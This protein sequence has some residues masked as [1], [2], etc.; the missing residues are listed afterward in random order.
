[1]NLLFAGHKTISL[2]CVQTKTILFCPTLLPI[3]KL[4]FSATFEVSHQYFI[5]SDYPGVVWQTSY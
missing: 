2:V 1:M 4:S 3:H 5:H